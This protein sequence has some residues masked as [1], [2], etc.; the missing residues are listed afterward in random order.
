MPILPALAVQF[1]GLF[2]SAN[3]GQERARWFML[4]RQAILLPII[5]SRTSNLLRTL[6]TL[7][8]VLIG[9]VA[10]FGANRYLSLALFDLYTYILGYVAPRT[11]GR[12]GGDFMVAPPSWPG[13]TPKGV[14]KV[15]RS[16]AMLALGLFRTQLFRAALGRCTSAR[17]A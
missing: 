12:L 4:T 8:G 14:K 11:N 10:S 7:F 9:T 1:Q 16:T 13:P 2:P 17:C 15:F 6:A 5:G 3:H